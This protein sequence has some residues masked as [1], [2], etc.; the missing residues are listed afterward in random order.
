MENRERNTVAIRTVLVINFKGSYMSK[1]QMGA[2]K[3]LRESCY[4][5]IEYFATNPLVALMGK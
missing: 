3:Y 2:E 5:Y 1:L 4:Y